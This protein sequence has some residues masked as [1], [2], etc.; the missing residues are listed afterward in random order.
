MLTRFK[1]LLALSRA[2]HALL[3]V[4]TPALGA[5]L[6][7]RAVPPLPVC[8]LG[9]VTAGA[10]YLAVYALNDLVDCGADREKMRDG[11]LGH[12]GDYLDAVGVR[13]PIARGL[14]SFR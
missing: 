10:A 5:I 12:D 14:L 11:G 2:T 13:H 8:L 9:L 6:C 3:D 7:V 4:A 1:L